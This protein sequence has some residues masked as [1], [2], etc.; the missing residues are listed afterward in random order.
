MKKHFIF[1]SLA[2]AISSV[3]FGQTTQPKLNEVKNN[4]KTAE[5]AA[6]ADAQ[7]TNNKTVTDKATLNAMFSKKRKANAKKRKITA[8]TLIDVPP[9][10]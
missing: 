5:N 1:F 2:I 3:S 4:P 7:I 10:E 9:V 8:I 6:K